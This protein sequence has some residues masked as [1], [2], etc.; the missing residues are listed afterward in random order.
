MSWSVRRLNFSFILS[1]L[2]F[3]PEQDSELLWYS[4]QMDIKLI[5]T[6]I[7]VIL[8]IVGYTPYILNTLK[9]KTKPHAFSWLIF[10]LIT[11][12]A[13]VA[14][15]SKGGGVG[16]WLVGF[17]ALVCFV[18]FVLAL[19]NGNRRFDKVDWILLVGALFSI[20]LWIFTSEPLL[21]VIL[22]S[23]IEVIAFIPALRKGYLKPYEETLFTYAINA[24][25]FTFG[26]IALSIFSITTVL[27]PV[28]VVVVNL[29]F[30]FILMYRRQVI[31]SEVVISQNFQNS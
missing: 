3:E 21:S 15:V 27:F 28:T 11:A 6:I 22:V 10:S 19:I 16:S 8:T 13:F 5:L 2:I 25:R 18:I 24:I 17:S 23:F 29:V 1:H 12:I 14:Q 30:I 31:S 7:A 20:A 4:V 9:Q 26:I